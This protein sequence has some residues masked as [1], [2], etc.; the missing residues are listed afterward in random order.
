MKNDTKIEEESI[1]YFKIDMRIFTNFDLST[2]KSEK[3]TLTK[4][5]NFELKR[6]RGLMF[7][8]TEDW[9]KIWGKTDLNFQKLHEELGKFA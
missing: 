7:N 1:C 3:F 4:V 6:Y 9:C 2:W 5:Y 8:G